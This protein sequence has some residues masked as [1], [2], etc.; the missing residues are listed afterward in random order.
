MFFFYKKNKSS[1]KRGKRGKH[2]KHGNANNNGKKYGITK[3]QMDA[4]SYAIINKKRLMV[5]AE[6]M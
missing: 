4:I 6:S 5:Y 2:G 1:G 3:K